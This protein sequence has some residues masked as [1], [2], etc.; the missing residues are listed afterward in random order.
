MKMTMLRRIDRWFGIPL[1]L[2]LTL[3]RKA[4]GW[5]Y[6]EPEGPIQSILFVKLAE[7]GSTVLA[8]GAIQRAVEMVG[9]ENVYFLVF[10]NNRFIVDALDLI[11]R[12]NV[13]TIDESNLPV[14]LLSSL[15]AVVR[16]FRQSI[17]AAIDMEF[18]ARSS[19]VFTFLSGSRRRVGFHRYSGGGAYR[20]NLMTHRLVYNP[21][22]HTSQIF[23]AMVESL[24]SAPEKF[25]SF[26]LRV[27]P[28][29]S[30]PLPSHVQLPEAVIT[31]RAIVQQA[32]ELDHIPPLI[33]LNANCSDLL[34]LRKWDMANYIELAR[35][36]LEQYPDVY[37]GLTGAPNEAK[38][39]EQVA[40]E[41]DS[42]RCLNFAGKTSMD[43]LLSLYSISRVLVTNDS[44]PAHFAT[45]TPIKTITLFGPETPLL[46]SPH[47]PRSNP[48]WAGIACSPCVSAYNNRVSNCSNNICMQRITVDQVFTKTCELYE[49]GQ[50]Q[51]DDA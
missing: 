47:S 38:D 20:G 40:R 50:A 26:D 21:H 5:L 6:S 29:D 15:V 46:F 11:P 36:L 33:L 8:Y 1:T 19:A 4:F 39:V 41:V 37:I 48:L 18:F 27:P 34:P 31:T 51:T 3:I 28:L 42:P 25:P 35:R 14:A 23:Y 45:L 44:G 2:G 10:D 24:N 12:D 43:E 9:R 49:R 17:D 30:F 22:L 16:V 7:Q 32:A 13:I